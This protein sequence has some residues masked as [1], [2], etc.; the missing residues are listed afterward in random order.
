M[1]RIDLLRHAESTYNLDPSLVGG[2]SNH[3]DLTPTGREQSIAAGRW[4]ARNHG[5]PDIIFVSPARRTRLTAMGVVGLCGLNTM[6]PIV[7][8]DTIQELSQGI[9]EGQ[10]RKQVWTPDTVDALLADPD[11]FKFVGGESMDDVRQRMLTSMQEKVETLP[12][13]R[14]LVVSHGLAIRALVG[15]IL[16]WSH[17]EILDANTPNA[18]L[19]TVHFDQDRRTWHVEQIGS[20]IVNET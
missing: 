20:N 14:L 7:Y 12:N 1:T 10:P 4:L 17:Q 11:Q 15:Q 6:T 8:D 16:D 5:Q 3:I 2:R 9:M 18:S 13:N 19:T